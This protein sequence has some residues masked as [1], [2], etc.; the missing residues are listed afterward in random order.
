[1]ELQSEEIS[2]DSHITPQPPYL[3][4]GWGDTE[5]EIAIRTVLINYILFLV[6]VAIDIYLMVKFKVSYPGMTLLCILSALYFAVLSYLLSFFGKNNYFL[7]IALTIKVSNITSVWIYQYMTY[8]FGRTNRFRYVRLKDKSDSTQY[9]L[10][11]DFIDLNTPLSANNCD[12]ASYLYLLYKCDNIISMSAASWLFLRGKCKGNEQVVKDYLNQLFQIFHY[13]AM[14]S[15]Q[16]TEQSFI[17][18]LKN[19]SSTYKTLQ[20]SEI[21][22]Q[23]KF[24]IFGVLTASVSL[25]LSQPPK[26]KSYREFYKK[27]DVSITNP[28]FV[29]GFVDA[30]ISII[31]KFSHW[32]YYKDSNCLLHTSNNYILWYERSIKIKEQFSQLHNPEHL[33]FTE[34]EFLHNLDVLITDGE[35]IAERLK[36]NRDDSYFKISNY[37]LTFKQLRTETQTQLLTKKPRDQPFGILL[38]GNSSIGKTSL[39]DMLFK[40]HAH[41]TGLPYGPEYRYDRNPANKHYDNYKSHMWVVVV[42]EFAPFHP[43]YY[44]PAILLVHFLFLG[45]NLC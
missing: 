19:F 15:Q 36:I 29:L 18:D 10:Q 24:V 7:L 41:V 30:S 42:D 34:T 27:V 45:L 5:P 38:F 16:Y 11:S 3:M 8:V 12:I 40:Y 43:L 32:V 33:G 9:E 20:N 13:T 39:Q 35:S 6:L 14:R 1:M 21:Y 37:V 26:L 25:G 44:Q 28:D 2:I 22:D 17:S 31:E 4:T 23:F